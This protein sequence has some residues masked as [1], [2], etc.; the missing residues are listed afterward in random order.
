MTKVPQTRRVV[1]G[2]Q[3]TIASP[4]TKDWTAN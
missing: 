3:A 4:T 1:S 2:G